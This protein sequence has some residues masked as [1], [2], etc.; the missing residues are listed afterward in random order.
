MTPDAVP[1]GPILSVTPPYPI[2]LPCPYP[3]KLYLVKKCCNSLYN[4]Q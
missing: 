3:A 1:C 2:P 4:W